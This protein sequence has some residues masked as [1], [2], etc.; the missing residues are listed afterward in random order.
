MPK[1]ELEDTQPS[2]IEAGEMGDKKPSDNHNGITEEETQPTRISFS[3]LNE[4]I[5]RFGKLAVLSIIF[6]FLVVVISSL[7]GFQNGRAVKYIRGTVTVR[8]YL[9]QQYARA[10]DEM[11]AG[12]YALAQQRLAYIHQQD[13]TFSEANEALQQV[14]DMLG[15]ESPTD[16]SNLGPTPTDTIDPRPAQQLFDQAATEL[17]AGQWD[18]TL[19]TI[20]ALRQGN[21]EFRAIEV[22]GMIYAALR[23]RGVDKILNQGELE[24]GLYDFSLAEQFGPIDR[25]AEIYRGWARLYMQGNGFWMAYPE[26]ALQYYGQVAAAAPGLHDLSGMSAFYRYWQ[27]LVQYADQLAAEG[28]WCQAWEYYD[29][30]VTANNDGEVDSKAFEAEEKCLALT[31]DPTQP[32]PTSTEPAATSTTAP[33]TETNVPEPTETQEPTATEETPSEDPPPE[34][35]PPDAAPPDDPGDTPTE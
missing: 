14:N 33:P 18:Q 32:K 5:N 17:A 15:E 3:K 28:D 25:D 35:P 20:S 10:L 19:K 26:I 9:E 7:W 12:D 29:T 16:P 22:D 34:D 13:P 2:R 8:L 23:N 27:S 1:N 4:I 31:P 24:G 30:A 21:P 11:A 6:L